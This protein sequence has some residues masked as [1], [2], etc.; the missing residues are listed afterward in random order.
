[1]ISAAA[2]AYEVL[3]VRLF[4]I[5]QWHQF[6]FMI[7]SVALLGYGAGGSFLS[8]WAARLETR[9]GAAFALQAA[10]FGIATIPCFLAAQALHFNPL[11]ALWDPG[12]ALRLGGIY[13]FLSLPFAFAACCIGLALG[14]YRERLHSVYACDLLGASTGAMGVMGLLYLVFPG[15]ALKAVAVLG[16][17]AALIACRGA[18]SPW[19]PRALVLAIAGL[20]VLPEGWVRPQPLPYKGLPQALEILGT[21]VIA[22]RSSPLGIL[23]VVESPRVPFR[24]APGL[25]L[26]APAEPPEQLGLFQDADGMSAITRYRGE[27]ATLAYLDYLPSALPYHVLVRPTVLVLGAGGG[28][29]VLQAVYHRARGIDAVELN[30]QITALLRE[31]F[32]DYTGGVLDRPEVRVHSADAR[33]FVASGD[34]RFDLIELSLLDTAGASAAGLQASNANYLYTVEALAAYLRRLTPGGIVAITRAVT[35]PPR[36]GLKLF[37]MA[38]AALE[39]EGEREPARRLAW[40]RGFKTHTLLIRNGAFEAEDR[41]RIRDFCRARSFDIAFLEDASAADSDRYNRLGQPYFL[42]G[43]QALLGPERHDFIRRYKFDISPATDDR[44]YFFQFFKWPLLRE[45]VA[46]RGAG[47]MSLL[48]LGYPVVLATLSQALCLSVALILAPL[49]VRRWRG[50]AAGSGPG[51]PLR[52]VVTF[53][54]IGFG[55]M[56]IEMAFIQKFGLYLGH[57]LLAVAVVLS[58][59]LVFAGLGSAAVSREGRPTRLAM[60]WPIAGITVLGSSYLV[61]LPG[62]FGWTSGHG[63]WPKAVLALIL[64]APLGFCMGKPFPTALA[65]LGHRAPALIP[66]AYGVNACASVIGAVLAMLFAMHLG[67]SALLALALGCYL[68]AFLA[69]A[70]MAGKR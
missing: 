33:G 28:A 22:E 30:P 35:L 47:G 60:A 2:L 51:L 59:F 27:R 20:L 3:L 24:Y 29:G 50:L 53:A 45:A 41:S 68:V 5:I 38:V 13:L 43:A 58:G 4:S 37:A 10:L 52:V 61:G 19:G 23:Q 70:A 39:A 67:L 64:V 66:W 11:E 1:L 34:G 26:N 62:V 46:M 65:L 63:M 44:P 31:D 48:E 55:F 12:Q 6:A 69:Y 40:I 14:H 17:F 9:F 42:E 32:R 56:F 7:I 25:S 8:L 57:P 54:A 21:R 36:D 16:L 15:T 18:G 49:G